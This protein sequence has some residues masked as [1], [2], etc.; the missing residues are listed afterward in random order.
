[1]NTEDFYKKTKPY[2]WNSDW[3]QEDE[4]FYGKDDMKQFAEEYHQ[5]KLLLGE[6]MQWV[7]VEDAEPKDCESI[8]GIEMPYEARYACHREDKLYISDETGESV[9]ITHWMYTPEPPCT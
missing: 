1:M 9:V 8:L 5:H 4:G 6:V 7:A 2:L 3:N